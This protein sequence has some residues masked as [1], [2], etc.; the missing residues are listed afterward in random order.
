MFPWRNRTTSSAGTADTGSAVS[1]AQEV[2][3]R[4]YINNDQLDLFMMVVT[5]LPLRDQRET[6]ERPFFSLS[7]S[8]RLKP[9]NYMSPDGKVSVYVS[10]N[11]D[12]GMATIW[13]LDI[14]IFCASVLHSQKRDGH[15]DIPQTLHFMPYDLLKAIGRPTTGR[16]YQLLGQSLDRL[17]STTVKTNIRANSRKEVTFSWIDSYTHLVDERT[18][19]TRGMSVTLAK[20]F[21]DG[22]LMENG[23][24]SI[25]SEYFNI[26]GGRERWLYRVARKHAG[27]ADETGFAIRFP[28]LFDKSGAEGSYRRFKFELLAI[29]KRNDLLGYH[30][31]IEQSGGEP[32]LRMIRRDKLGGAEARALSKP[33]SRERLAPQKPSPATE[34]S[35]E[36]LDRLRDE[37]PGWDYGRLEEIFREWLREDESRTPANY[38]RA[39][40]CFVKRYHDRNKYQLRG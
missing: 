29:A 20:W 36:T 38:D 27:G 13:D 22:V 26:T 12:Y 5:D 33:K 19:R 32:M 23:V 34:A 28:V 18:E 35:I 7:K 11:P 16:A 24:L 39:F 4:T 21:Y 9:I 25:D 2:R 1:P 3:N 30:L 8:K 10:A 31:Q 40:Y 6:M 17:Q 15:N 14:L 37:F